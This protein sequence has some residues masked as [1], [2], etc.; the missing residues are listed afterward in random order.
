[1]R[2]RF[3]SLGQE[4][5]ETNRL[6]K[7]CKASEEGHNLEDVTWTGRDKITHYQNRCKKCGVY[8]NKEQQA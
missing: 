3:L 2:N 5:V 4:M 7:L 8:F 6:Y 1:M